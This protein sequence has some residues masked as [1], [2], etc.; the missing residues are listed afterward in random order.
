MINLRLPTN[1]TPEQA[2]GDPSLIAE[3]LS[4]LAH[5]VPN[6]LRRVYYIN[7]TLV[8]QI[9][10]DAQAAAAELAKVQRMSELQSRQNISQVMTEPVSAP[11]A[12]A[13]Q[14]KP[15]TTSLNA[16]IQSLYDEETPNHGI[17]A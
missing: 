9:E 13:E 15:D 16:Y 12:A 3:R 11:L 17:A 4:L 7:P 1:F 14:D 8:G 5:A 2:P 10:A 6:A